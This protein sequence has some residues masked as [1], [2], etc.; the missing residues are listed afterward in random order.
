MQ[1]TVRRA[2]GE[3][4]KQELHPRRTLCY[5][6]KSSHTALAVHVANGDIAFD[7]S[8]DFEVELC[9]ARRPD[10]M[11]NLA[12]TKNDPKRTLGS[13]ELQVLQRRSRLGAF[14]ILLSFSS[15][16]GTGRHTLVLFSKLNTLRFP[17]PKVLVSWLL[18]TL[19][20]SRIATF[21]LF[22]KVITGGRA[23]TEVASV[24]VLTSDGESYEGK[25]DRNGS[26]ILKLPFGKANQA[27]LKSSEK[28][29]NGNALLSGILVFDVVCV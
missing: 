5:H 17:H 29:E 25:T 9:T 3:Q 14:E 22:P 13:A 2:R 28:D 6:F 11:I 15:K 19:H 16:N 10:P 23:Y 12:L 21:Q 7:T 1:S 26:C 4:D 24:C 27:T 20:P 18:K 8:L